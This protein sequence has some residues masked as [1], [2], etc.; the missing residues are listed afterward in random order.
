M[1]N[2]NILYV[3]KYAPNPKDSY[4]NVM[5]LSYAQY[6]EDIYNVLKENFSNVRS[7]NDPKI[8]LTKKPKEDF[9]CSLLNRMPF[10]NSEIFISS[11]MEY[12]R[13]PYLGAPPNIRAIAEDKVLAKT[14]A[15]HAGIKTPQWT[16]YNINCTLYPPNFNP[17]YFI[18]P[19]FGATSSGV[20]ENSICNSWEEA[21][22]QMK[23]LFLQFSDVLLEE[24]ILGNSYTCP[25]LYNFGDTYF[26]PPVHE[27][28]NLKGN[29][30]TYKQKRKIDTGLLRE[31]E[32]NTVV[33]SKLKQA[34]QKFYK[35]VQ[36]LDYTR[37]EYIMKEN[38]ELY[39]IEFNVCCNLGKQAA[40][41]L[42]ASSKGFSYESLINNI[43]VSSMYR[44]RITDIVG[45]YKF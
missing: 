42:S 12:Y 27:T 13:K 38:G 41:Y 39:F 11:L 10:R 33:L 2:K 3:A 34:N 32:T 9:V 40:I 37:I 1:V 19:R 24:Y 15:L 31:T 16:S 20:D 5:D 8:L 25:I 4:G 28:S 17:P 22:V 43:I 45:G 7:I 6:H 14:V 29:I 18:K 30:I 44:Q 23:K 35:L 36:P 26:L 21:V